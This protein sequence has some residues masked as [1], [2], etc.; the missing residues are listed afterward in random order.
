[1]L[2]AED[3]LI[4]K[5][6][7]ALEIGRF[8]SDEKF[9][10]GIKQEY[11]QKL[12][13]LN[14]S[15]IKMQNIKNK[16]NSKLLESKDLV[17]LKGDT[18]LL[19]ALNSSFII[20]Y[21]FDKDTV[22][23]RIDLPNE[24]SSSVYSDKLTLSKD[25]KKLVAR[26]FDTGFNYALIDLE[27]NKLISALQDSKADYRDYCVN[28][29]FTA[30]YVVQNTEIGPTYEHKIIKFSL[31]D[32]KPIDTLR[33]DNIYN[34]LLLSPIVLS[35]NKL[36]IASSVGKVFILDVSQNND[37]NQYAKFETIQIPKDVYQYIN[38]ILKYKDKYI[39]IENPDGLLFFYNNETKIIE[40]RKSIKHG[41]L[42]INANQSKLL[43][44]GAALYDLDAMTGIE[45]NH[46]NIISL[47]PNP[48]N[49]IVTI[50]NNCV[51]PRIQYTISN[52]LGQIL[53]TNIAN[54][55]NNQ[56]QV[57]FSSYPQGAY[58]LQLQCNGNVSS[59][60]VVKE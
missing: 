1:M 13:I 16:E 25:K 40:F 17:I 18:T 53:F 38:K 50:Q 35:D 60:K 56:I 58:F 4:W 42:S 34:T 10:F 49:S 43:T 9:V 31:P 12:N 24:G 57:D 29:D 23:K 8:T 28:D 52:Q 44:A 11:I 3:G 36:A 41:M 30:M 33:L 32:F 7:A 48:T 45:D 19:F 2:K 27:Q 5:T 22:T 54:N 47:H 46:S 26:Y 14:G 21:N 51:L 6:D 39:I 37:L 59:Y 20:L 15:V 55:I